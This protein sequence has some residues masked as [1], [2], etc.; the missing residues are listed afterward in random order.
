M[1]ISIIFEKGHNPNSISES[2]KPTADRKQLNTRESNNSF[3][4]PI[5]K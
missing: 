5:S 1:D 2:V 4:H 3:V